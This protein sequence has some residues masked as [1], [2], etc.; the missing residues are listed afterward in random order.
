[1]MAAYNQFSEEHQYHLLVYIFVLI[2]KFFRIL[3]VPVFLLNSATLLHQNNRHNVCG[4]RTNWS[5]YHLVSV[6]SLRNAAL[7]ECE[8]SLQMVKTHVYQAGTPP[9]KT[10]KNLQTCNLFLV[11]PR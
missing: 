3:Q 1:M 5:E 9:Q 6:K 8:A 7:W 4:R 11:T 10:P 2:L